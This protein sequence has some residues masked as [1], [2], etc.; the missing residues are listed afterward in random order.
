MKVIFEK[1][2]NDYMKCISIINHKESWKENR[3]KPAH[4]VPALWVTGYGCGC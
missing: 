1:W 3:N 4:D 2:W